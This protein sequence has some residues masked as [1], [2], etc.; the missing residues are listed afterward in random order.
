VFNE[1][2]DSHAL[3]V[4]DEAEALFGA[5]GDVRHGTDRYANLEVSY[6]LQRFELSIDPDEPRVSFEAYAALRVNAL[7]RGDTYVFKA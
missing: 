4:F 3:L 1:A 7:L 2:R 6:L 5:R